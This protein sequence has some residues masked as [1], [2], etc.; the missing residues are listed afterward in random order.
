MIFI[1]IHKNKNFCKRLFNPKMTER[2]YRST[3]ERG[4]EWKMIAGNGQESRAGLL[5]KECFHIVPTWFPCL[6]F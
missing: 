5:R 3:E 6:T 2:V 1:S 4:E